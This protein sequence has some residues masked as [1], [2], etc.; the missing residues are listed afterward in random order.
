MEVAYERAC[1]GS[2]A[3]MAEALI[4]AFVEAIFTDIEA[5]IGMYAGSDDMEGKRIAHAMHVLAIQAMSAMLPTA[6]GRS[7]A[8]LDA[9]ATTLMSE[10]AGVSRRCWK[11]ERLAKPWTK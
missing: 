9:T 5:S 3:V 4:E 10:M 6:T 7:L 2:L 1:G 11:T 8:D